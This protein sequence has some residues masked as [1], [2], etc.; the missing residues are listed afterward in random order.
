MTD[1][2]AIIQNIAAG[3]SDLAADMRASQERF[4]RTGARIEARRTAMK[5]NLKKWSRTRRIRKDGGA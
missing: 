2:C 3:L 4:Y 1:S 5:K